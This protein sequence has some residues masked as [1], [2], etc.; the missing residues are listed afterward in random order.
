MVGTLRPDQDRPRT[1][2]FGLLTALMTKARMWRSARS[3]T[4]FSP[5]VCRAARCQ[6]GYSLVCRGPSDRFNF[7]KGEG[8]RK[9]SVRQEMLP[10]TSRKTHVC[11]RRLSD[12]K[13]EHA[14]LLSVADEDLKATTVSAPKLAPKYMRYV[15]DR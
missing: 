9:R 7:V 13:A 8:D 2:R 5:R 10:L 15:P 6:R 11:C 1:T 12:A 14:E 4:E 3:S